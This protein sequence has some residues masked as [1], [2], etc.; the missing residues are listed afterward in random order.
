[1][2]RGYGNAIAAPFLFSHPS[3]LEHDTGAHPE[4]ARRIQAIEAELGTREWLGW[5][6]REAPQVE[7]EQLL[8][9]HPREHVELVRETCARGAAFDLDTPTSPGTWEAALRSAGAG[10][11]MVDALLARGDPDGVLRAAPARATTPSPRAPWA[12]ACSPTSLWP[13]ATRW[14]PAWSG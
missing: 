2:H 12:S 7:I 5:E 8:R 11:A 10:C 1:M 3:S 6:R 9:V 13:P 4:N 14:P